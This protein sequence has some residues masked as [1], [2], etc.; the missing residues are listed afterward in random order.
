MSIQRPT[1]A[2]LAATGHQLGLHIEAPLLAEY[3]DILEAVWK[4]YDLLEQLAVPPANIRYPRTEGYL[5]TPAQNPYNA[6]YVRT[7]LQGAAEGKLS[8]K[9]LAMKDNICLAGVPMM[10]GS[11][12]LH[13][14][15]PDIDATVVSRVLDAGGLILGKAHCEFFCV[16]GSSHTNATGAVHNPRNPGHSTGGSSSGCA[17]LIA[18]GEVDLGIGTDQGGSVRIPA[19]Y[20][21][22]YGIKPTHGLIPYTG[23]MPIEMTLDHAGVMS[24][25]VADNA[26]LLEVLAGADGLDPRQDR[27][28]P[29]QPYTQALGKGLKGLRIG[30]VSEGFGHVNSEADVD[31]AV[32]RAAGLFAEWGAVV[33]E[34][35]IPLHALGHA[36]WTPIA[37]EGTTKLLQGYNYGSNWKGLYVESLMRAQ[38][39]WQQQADTF[40]HDL[41]TCLLAGEYAHKRYSGQYYARA[42]NAARQL[43]AAYDEQLARFDLL[44]MPTVP[45]KAPKLPDADASASTW[46][47]RALEM[48]ANTAPFD[49]TGHPAISIPC[50]LAQGLPVGLM[51]IARD[52]DEATLYQAAYGFEQQIDWESLTS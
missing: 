10:N 24:A 49:V 48:N 41:K 28:M 11:S 27:H 20:S 26:L 14:Y 35:S 37:V 2:E 33:E 1:Q 16:S 18:A 23:I 5:P 7:D 12:T 47:V 42:Q 40:P 19:A 50:G 15:V 9:R 25:N 36:I 30:V 6:W 45:M 22:I 17:A 46:V 13:G 8:G 31:A 3:A 39:D 38:D 51:L 52:Y 21:G 34:V 32:R 4:D 44:L 29:V 43:R